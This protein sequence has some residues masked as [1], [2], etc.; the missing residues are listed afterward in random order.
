MA[1]KT[2]G[3]L[4][5]RK[6]VETNGAT[7]A[8]G[9][10]D[11]SAYVNPLDG[12]VLRVKKCWFEWAS[13]S[14]GPVLAADVNSTDGTASAMAQL[15]TLS[16]DSIKQMTNSSLFAKHQITM[17][18][19]NTSGTTLIILKSEDFAMNPAEFTDGFLVASDTIQLG[20]NCAPS[21]QTFASDIECQVII[22][23]ERVKMSEKDAFALISEQSQD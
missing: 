22:E 1:R 12:D 13:D 10:I 6:T 8:S 7:Y 4:F 14:G 2:S 11:V 5:L 3:T 16:Q 9:N 21:P 20:V 23:C 18:V 19:D 17:T 15:T